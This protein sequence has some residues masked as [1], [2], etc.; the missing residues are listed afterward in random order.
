MATTQNRMTDTELTTKLGG[1]R[2]EVAE[3][4]SGIDNA[5]ARLA[6]LKGQIKEF[7]KELKRREKWAE[8]TNGKQE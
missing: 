6:Y 5:R 3:V 2:T 7:E 1:L 8:K 4:E